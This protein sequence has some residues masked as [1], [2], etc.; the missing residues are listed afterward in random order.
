MREGRKGPRTK[1]GFTKFLGTGSLQLRRPFREGWAGRW[2][3]LSLRPSYLSIIPSC[4]PPRC[5]CEAHGNSR[6]P[7]TLGQ[8]ESSRPSLCPGTGA[9]WLARGQEDQAPPE[10]RSPLRPWQR[11]SLLASHLTVQPGQ[12]PRRVPV[13]LVEGEHSLGYWWPC[14]LL[15][16]E[17]VRS[18]AQ[19]W[20]GTASPPPPLADARDWAGHSY[21][22]VAS[23]AHPLDPKRALW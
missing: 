5:I 16:S 23:W 17:G 14:P 1:W 8:R 13:S 4:S 11:A 2:K 22:Q 19:A 6:S 9:S 18:L 7:R 10:S 21:L 12:G 15:H 20:H 3:F